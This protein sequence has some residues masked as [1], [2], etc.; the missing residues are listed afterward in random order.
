MTATGSR[1]LSCVLLL[2]PLMAWAAPRIGV[3]T[4]QPGHIFWERFGHNAILVVDDVAGTQTSYNFG[5]FDPTEPDFIARFVRGEMRYR[6]AAL[7]FEQDLAVYREEGRGVSV[8]WLDLPAANAVAMAEALAVNA[9]PENAAYGYQY[10]EDNCSTRV[11]DAIDRALDGALRGQ[12]QAGSQ[13]STYRSEAVRLASPAWW[14][15]TGFDVGLGPYADRMMSRWEEAFIPTRLAASLRNVRNAQGRPIVRAET[16]ILPHRIAPEPV[17]TPRPWWPWLLGG[18]GASIALLAMS[19]RHPRLAV[20][21]AVPL[22]LAC[23]VLSL[24]ML[25]IWLG[26]AHQFG[27]ANRNLLLF[28]PLAWVL[29]AGAW[30]VLRRRAVPRW[31]AWTAV[32]VAVCAIVAFFA[33]VLPLQPQRNATWVALLLPVHCAIA[34][35]LGRRPA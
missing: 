4:M 5:Y 20:A 34:W 25:F 28:N 16:D 24:L 1:L 11:R 32:A 17:D 26:T 8:Q 33:L 13:G 3:V 10:F 6:L 35:M 15:S 31:M 12:L 27:W 9:R 19:R 21:L 22:W 7:P 2:C 14:M 29:L 18:I 23:G 30:P